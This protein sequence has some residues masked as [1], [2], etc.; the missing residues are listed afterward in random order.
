MPKG[1]TDCK[2][3]RLMGIDFCGERDI[4][5]H[6]LIEFQG[7][8]EMLGNIGPS[9]ARANKTAG[10]LSKRRGASDRAPGTI[11][12][13]DKQFPSGVLHDKPLVARA[14]AIHVRSK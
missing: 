14:A 13:R 11:F 12:V 2:F 5:I 6:S 9:I 3:R 7:H 8:V 10:K 1:N 4:P